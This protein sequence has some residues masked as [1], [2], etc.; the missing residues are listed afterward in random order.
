[1]QS[2]SSTRERGRR[3]SE[4]G[5]AGTSPD[6]AETA[7]P[8]EAAEAGNIADAAPRVPRAVAADVSDTADIAAPA[9]STSALLATTGTGTT[10]G[11]Q[12]ASQSTSSARRPF[13]SSG[14]ANARHASNVRRPL[15][16]V[17]R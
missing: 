16:I 4:M 14:R 11:D 3:T 13:A 17:P 2:S 5:A 12:L 7:A 1:M 8:A 15:D 10:I 9:L 6:A